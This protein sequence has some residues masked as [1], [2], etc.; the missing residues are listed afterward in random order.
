MGSGINDSFGLV[1]IGIAGGV[2][3]EFN[4][5]C[6]AILTLDREMRSPIAIGITPVQAIANKIVALQ[7]WEKTS[8]L[9]QKSGREWR[10]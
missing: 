7:S 8:I 2:V 3:L 9:R 10:H 5:C 4:N 1:W 6:G